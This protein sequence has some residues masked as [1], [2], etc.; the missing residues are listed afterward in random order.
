MTLLLLLNILVSVIQAQEV[1]TVP[2][3]C[4]DLLPDMY[5][6]IS[7]FEQTGDIWAVESPEKAQKIYDVLAIRKLYLETTKNYINPIDEK[8]KNS[9][10]ECYYNNNE[11]LFSA[12]SK[13]IRTCFNK[14]IGKLVKETKN[15]YISLRNKMKKDDNIM[16]LTKEQW[17]K[18]QNLK[19]RSLVKMEKELT[20]V[21]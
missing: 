18:I 4:N 20:K 5:E 10:C 7:F 9:I 15:E 13:I 12:D 19:Y 6:Y 3:T 14:N 11:E 21:K 2:K 1:R 8:I 17:L 16:R